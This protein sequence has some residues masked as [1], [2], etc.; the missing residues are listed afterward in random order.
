M[1][2]HGAPVLDCLLPLTNVLVL[3][4]IILAGT[5]H[6]AL[7]CFKYKNES[8]SELNPDGL[9]WLHNKNKK[10]QNLELLSL[11]YSVQHAGMVESVMQKVGN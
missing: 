1:F 6:F 9:H 3:S 2:Q 5:P 10:I 11:V 4:D 7:N 8:Y